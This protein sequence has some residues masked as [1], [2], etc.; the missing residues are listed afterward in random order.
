[1]GS[2]R[3]ATGS[4]RAPRVSSPYLRRPGDPV[5]V[6]GHRGAAA[7]APENTFA[8]FAL[9]EWLGADLVEL[10]VRRAQ[11]GELVVIHDATVDRTTDG[12][13]RVADLTGAEIR[14]LDAGGWFD[15]RFAGERVPG[16]D[17]L[18]AWAVGRRV[19]LSVEL[20]QD[21]SV[22]DDA[23]AEAVVAV[24]RRHGLSGRV[25]VH[26]FD[27]RSIIDVR[28]R[29]PEIATALL[30]AATVSDPLQAA[31][32]VDAGGVHVAW[33]RA[34]APFCAAAHAAGRHVHASGLDEP[35]D[36]DRVGRL[37]DAGV[38]SL[39]ADDPGPLVD[40]L[41]ALGLHPPRPAPV[42]R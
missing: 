40:L 30:C 5:R 10:D 14:G 31:A 7:L 15:P 22:R 34:T 26:S 1:M 35:L 21:P 23:L 8:S 24:L 28:T 13:G 19:R 11:D 32:A 2:S 6:L 42:S 20:K 3:S 27:P 16:F 36:R 9:A 18:C 33:Q 37:V 38:D 4:R 17:A 29:A 39:E 25:L 12:H 41:A